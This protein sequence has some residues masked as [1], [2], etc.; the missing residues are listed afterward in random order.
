MKLKHLFVVNAVINVSYGLAFI[1]APVWL[2]SLHEAVVTP[3]GVLMARLFG[4]AIL[5]TGLLLWQLR[6]DETSHAVVVARSYVVPALV[7]G[8]IFMHA[9]LTGVVNWM[10]WSVVAIYLVFAAAYAALT[11]GPTLAEL[12]GPTKAS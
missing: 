9:T 7:A 2:M 1:V 4:A 3:A 5:G 12:R 11:V 8:L 6:A 10:G